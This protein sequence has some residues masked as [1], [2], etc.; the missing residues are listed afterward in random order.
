VA[1]IDTVQVVDAST[2]KINLKA[3]NATLLATLTDRAG[4]MM[5]PAAIDKYGKDL[6]RNPVGT[7]PFKFV[8]WVKDDHLTLRRNESYWK[9][10]LPLLDEVRYRPILDESVKLAALKGGEIDFIDYAPATDVAA[11]T[12]DRARA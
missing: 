6:A 5:S 12:G 3:P 2:V 8:E 7:G 4:M 1:S 11:L 10:G 9:P